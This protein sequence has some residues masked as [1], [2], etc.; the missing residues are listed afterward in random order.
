MVVVGESVTAPPAVGVVRES[1]APGEGLQ[2]HGP[3]GGKAAE[4]PNGP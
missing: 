1:S 2:N 4:K 3:V